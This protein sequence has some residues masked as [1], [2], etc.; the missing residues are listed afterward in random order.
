MTALIRTIGATGSITIATLLP[1]IGAA[2]PSCAQCT[3]QPTSKITANDGTSGDV[4]G[5]SAAVEGDLAVIGA[6]WD[7]DNGLN[8]G[9]AYVFER[10]DDGR[11]IQ[12][13]KL[14]AGDGTA[15]D[16]FGRDVAI[17]DGTIAVGANG[18]DASRG[19]VY[20]FVRIGDDWV[21]EAK[22]VASD[23]APSDYVGWHVDISGDRI[24]TGGHGN[25]IA[26]VDSG[27]AYVFER[28]GAGV[29]TEAARLTSQGLA[30]GDAFG[31]DVAISGDTL[32]VGAYKDD[33]D[34]ESSGSVY[35]F[36]REP[37]GVWRQRT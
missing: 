21:Q 1:V 28:D 9:S 19:A 16:V 5:I 8:S 33:D 10:D 25:D 34:G 35:V 37:N 15:Q 11:W 17:S 23:A 24:V 30:A 32:I 36:E 27:S 26:G 31:H 13:A 14:L 7:D 12:G 29:W 2:R 22:L 3:A 6:L 4:F 18:D 20:V